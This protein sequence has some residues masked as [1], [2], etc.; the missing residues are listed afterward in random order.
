MPINSAA[1]TIN[2]VFVLMLENRSF[3]H[4]LGFS[5]IAGIDAMTGQPTKIAG[6]NGTESNSFAG[7]QY[8]VT[9]P[10]DWVLALDPAHEFL[11]VVTQLCGTGATYP[12]GGAYPPINCSGFVSDYSSVGGQSDPATIMKCYEPG[13]LPVLT[14]LAKEFAVCDQWYSSMPGPTWPNRFFA[15]AAS[16]GGLDHSPSAAE[17]ALWETLSGFRFEKGT[18]FDALNELPND[19]TWRIYSGGDFPNAAAL[20]GINNSEIRYLQDF[21]A[22]VTGNAYPY[23]Y[24]FIEPNYGDVV[25]GTFRGG[26][27]QHPVD[28]VTHGEALIKTIYEAI[29]SSAVWETALLIVTWDEHGGFFDH[30]APPPAVVP[31]D[32]VVTDGA[33]H[34]NFTFAQ[35]GSRVPAV[36][37]SPLVPRNLIDHRVYDHASIPATVEAIFGLSPLTH[38]DAHA[39][40]LASLASLTIPRTNTPTTLPNPA[41]STGTLTMAAM[42]S[43][44][45]TADSID[46][47]NLPGFLGTALRSDLAL[48]PANEHPAILARFRTIRTR[49]AAQRYMDEVRV[50][51]RA[52]RAATTNKSNRLNQTRTT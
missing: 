15:H 9:Q 10:A 26:N 47:G 12:A 28:D 50:K 19:H 2:H 4:M 6:L 43:A 39:N 37:V 38:R 3:D 34:Y 11:N 16:S 25:F 20:K 30:V 40:N 35:Y 22:D 31:G 45:T 24:T 41:T 33:S 18:I 52:G 49:A 42:P 14:S 21:P 5:G 48:S 44:A 23:L 7:R 27:S 8:P 36:V 17:I 29:R 13:Q 1:R 51:V 46:S 32:H